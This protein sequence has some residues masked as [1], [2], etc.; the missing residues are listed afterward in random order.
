MANDPTQPPKAIGF[1]DENLAYVFAEPGPTF[2]TV[3]VRIIPKDHPNWVDLTLDWE[4]AGDLGQFLLDWQ[5]W[6]LDHGRNQQ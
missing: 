3:T 6:Y 2:R 4:T 5:K 1:D